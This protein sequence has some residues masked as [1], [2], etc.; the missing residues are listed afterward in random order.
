[1]RVPA[2]YVVQAK[3][4]DAQKPRQHDRREEESNSMRAVVLKRE[5]AH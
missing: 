1:M 3:G 2:E 5:Q 4:T